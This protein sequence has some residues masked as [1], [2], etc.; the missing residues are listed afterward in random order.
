MVEMISL[1]RVS[2]CWGSYNVTLTVSITHPKIT[3][4]V[5]QVKSPV[6]ILFRYRTSC[7]FEFPLVFRGWKTVSITWNN[8]RWTWRRL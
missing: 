1:K 2:Q 7:S 6:S 3:W 8:F 5:Y 4:Q